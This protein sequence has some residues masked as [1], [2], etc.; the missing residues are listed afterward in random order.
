MGIDSTLL[1]CS[2]N[3]LLFFPRQRMRGKPNCERPRSPAHPNDYISRIFLFTC[4]GRARPRLLRGNF[5]RTSRRTHLLVCPASD[6][7]K[8][9]SRP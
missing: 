8:D 7:D 9:D 3:T 5:G 4:A 6:E 2:T 1:L